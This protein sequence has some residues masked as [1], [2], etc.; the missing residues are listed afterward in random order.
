MVV[1]LDDTLR[2]AAS[3][4]AQVCVVCMRGVRGVRGVRSGD[5]G[6]KVEHAHYGEGISDGG[7]SREWW[8][9]SECGAQPLAVS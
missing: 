2:P 1:A 3:G 5:V 7:R 4:V 6:W 8:L 9:G